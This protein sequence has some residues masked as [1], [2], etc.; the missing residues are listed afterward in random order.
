MMTQT[1]TPPMKPGRFNA[2]II[3]IILGPLVEELLFRGALFEVISDRWGSRTALFTV[4]TFA[5]VAHYSAISTVGVA[6]ILFLSAIVFT[7][8]YIEG[9][10]LITVLVHSFA[11][12]LILSN[13][14]F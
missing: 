2:I 12:F 14:S 13:A 1:K 7:L 9:G 6:I 11:N 5:L 3:T 8:A 4:S 10:L